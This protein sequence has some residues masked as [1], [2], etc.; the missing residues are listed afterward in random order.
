MINLQPP[1]NLHST[2]MKANLQPPPPICIYGGEGLDAQMEAPL[3]PMH[4]PFIEGRRYR[5][6][7]AT[8]LRSRLDLYVESKTG[9]LRRHHGALMAV[10]R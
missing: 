3:I 4:A 8:E 1:L 2:S 10:A 6:A 5:T 9:P 7:G